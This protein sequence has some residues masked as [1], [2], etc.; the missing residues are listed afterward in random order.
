MT[1]VFLISIHNKSKHINANQLAAIVRAMSIQLSRDVAPIWGQTPTI[2]VNGDGAPCYLTD[3]ADIDGAYGYHDMVEGGPFMKVFVDPILKDGGE[4]LK[5]SLSVSAVVSH[6]ILETI[7]DIS[8]NLWAEYDGKDYALELCDAVEGDWYEIDGVSVSN[9]VYPGFFNPKA[10]VNEALDF[11]RLVKTPFET[12]PNGYQIVR[13]L[14][15]YSKKKD[16]AVYRAI[17]KIYLEFGENFAS[18]R[19]DIKLRA[20]AQRY[21]HR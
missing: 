21:S 3:T 15:R 14:A 9:F 4:I 17:D 13:R 11:M 7:G 20:V 18:H 10:G 16:L 12:R 19:K 5:G 2:E 8:A 6:E 1:P